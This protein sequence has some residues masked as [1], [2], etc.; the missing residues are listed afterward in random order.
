MEKGISMTDNVFSL[1]DEHWIPVSYLDGHPAEISLR[2]I[3]LDAP[4]IKELSGDIPQQ[5][6]PLMRFLLAIMYRA[7][8]IDGAD[9]EQMRELWEGIYSSG[10]FNEDALDYYFDEWADRFFLLGERPF[11]QVP[12]LQYVG[13]KPYSPV[14]EMIADVPKPDKYLFSM[15][16]LRAADSLLPAEA[17]RWL[18][19]LQAYDT[20]GIKTP[21]EGNT[22]VNK[23][24]VYAP[25]G[26]LG[27]GWLGGIGGLYAEGRNLFETLMLNWVL[28][29]TKFD[30]ERYRLF[31]NNQDIPVWE[32]E[33]P[34]STDLNDQNRFVGPVQA[35]TWQSRRV[36]LVPSE[37]NARI[38]GIMSCYGDV[39]APYNTDV[40]EKMT[41]WRSS[42]TQQK[43]L[44]LPAPPH[45]PVVHD[46]GKALWRGL[47]PILC[48]S[49]EGDSRPGLIR[50]LEEIRTEILES[51]K[52]VLDLVTIHAQGMTY[53]TQSSVFE[54][55]IDDTLSLNSVMFRHDY[56]GIASVLD[57]V[58]CTDGAVLALSQFVRNLRAAS[59]DK[60]KSTETAEQVREW[61]YADLDGLFRDELAA[62]DETQDPIE[63]ANAWKDE[64][65]RRLLQMGREYLD[66]SPVPV[67]GEH[68]SGV[69]GMMGAS[70]AQLLF[71]S[72]LNKELGFIER[73]DSSRPN[74]GGM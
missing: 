70:R 36:R 63:Y 21:V 47:E 50:W 2:E 62:F 1:L 48:A 22:H 5:K 58:K 45:M 6:L 57:V 54:T 64:I 39:V 9:E 20:A 3:F 31:G 15:R 18:V 67:F 59:G 25:K 32:R 7:Y 69:M 8:C 55:G 14:S 11:F 28:Y 42:V 53:G 46:A 24:K 12:G 71:Q 29:D 16:D 43:K 33:D 40:F 61:A 4:K 44:G 51:E 26:M 56:S 68:E 65:H 10:Q 13:S 27:T 37:D 19:F 34:P 38:I 66:Q 52:H 17:A 49:D 74:K 35:M 73:E 41:A 30:S 23:G 60:G 72:K